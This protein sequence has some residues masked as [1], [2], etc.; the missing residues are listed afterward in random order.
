M[1]CQLRHVSGRPKKISGR[2]K[3]RSIT[4]SKC[5]TF[6]R[7]TVLRSSPWLAKA[8]MCTRH[9]RNGQG[10]FWHDLDR[11]DECRSMR[12]R[13]GCVCARMGSLS[14]G[15]RPSREAPLD[16]LRSLGVNGGGKPCAEPASGPRAMA[17]GHSREGAVREVAARGPTL[18]PSRRWARALALSRALHSVRV[19][20]G[21]GA[22]CRR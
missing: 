3:T 19:W 6:R 2:S 13:A 14:R 20:R 9:L 7:L 22:G 18:R 1:R 21:G 8:C 5:L 17:V 16:S 4:I 11:L 10:Y 15:R 12:H